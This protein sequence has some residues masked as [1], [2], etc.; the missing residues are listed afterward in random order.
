VS[1]DWVGAAI[2][3]VFLPTAIRG[4]AALVRGPHKP[5]CGNTRTGQ[6]EVSYRGEPLAFEELATAAAAAETGIGHRPRALTREESPVRVRTIPSN[7]TQIARSGTKKTA[8]GA[9]GRRAP[10]REGCLRSAW[11]RRKTRPQAAL[12][13]PSRPHLSDPP[14]GDILIEV[15][16]G[17]FKR[18][19]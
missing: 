5:S 4:T 15:N 17:H 11:G 2:K 9:G 14:K 16:R 13:H 1:N 10:G 7:A 12:Q 8:A 19:F 6:L 18:G 3:D